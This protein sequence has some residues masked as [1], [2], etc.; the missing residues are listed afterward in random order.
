MN[1]RITGTEEECAAMVN[2]IRSNIPEYYIKSIS[3]WYRNDRNVQFST[4]G[5][6]YCNF[7]DMVSS[8]L[9]QITEGDL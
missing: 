4:E 6:V 1:L 3:E 8:D 2:L 9:K 5:R 7:R